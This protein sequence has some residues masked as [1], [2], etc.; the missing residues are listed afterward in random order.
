MEYN[1]DD[2]IKILDLSEKRIEELKKMKVE[3]IEINDANIR[4][5]LQ[6]IELDMLVGLNNRWDKINNWLELLGGLHKL[7][8]FDIF[9][10]ERFNQ[11]LNSQYL[12]DGLPDV[13]MYKDKY[14]ISGNGKHRLTIGKCLGEKT[15]TVALRILNN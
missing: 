10:K 5:I 13:V 8:N 7:K 6:V 4:P 12:T 2:R 1:L 14:Y 11:V 15:A 3:R 9:K